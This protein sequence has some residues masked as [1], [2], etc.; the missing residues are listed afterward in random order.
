MSTI[1]DR[2]V[3]SGALRA[4]GETAPLT[5]LGPWRLLR[6][7]ASGAISDVYQARPRE[8]PEEARASYAVKLLRPEWHN[9]R[10]AVELVRR[11]A[12]AGRTVSH[13]HLVPVLSAAVDAPPYFVVTPW[14]EG[15]SLDRFLTGGERLPLAISLWI[16]RQVA[17]ALEALHAAGWMH[18][19]IKPENL[20]VGPGCHITLMDLGFARRVGEAGSAAER[21][22]VG[23]AN[24]IAPEAF[25]SKLATDIRSDIYSLG[26]TLF[27]LLAGRPPFLGATCE[28]VIAAQQSQAAP[29]LRCLFPTIPAGV[30]ELVQSMLAKEPL[31]RP[32]SPNELINRLVRLEIEALGER[33]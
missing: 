12:L 4:R 6:R 15:E 26:A 14:I 20:L 27:Q 8:A 18:C 16:V 13:R 5:D 11:E 3:D 25:T 19:D 21:V 7:V 31:R 29:K 10:E 30:A 24:Y 32:Q 33:F 17:E 22:V 1:V 28:A 9:R 2:R 23:T